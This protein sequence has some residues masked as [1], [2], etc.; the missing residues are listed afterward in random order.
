MAPL[1]KIYYLDLYLIPNNKIPNEF[2]DN[3]GKKKP[4]PSLEIVITLVRG[5]KVEILYKSIGHRE[6]LKLTGSPLGLTR[7]KV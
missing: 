3:G 1:Q 6:D 2:K 4:N 7:I 5:P